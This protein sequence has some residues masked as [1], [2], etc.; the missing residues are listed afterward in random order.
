VINWASFALYADGYPFFTNYWFTKYPWE[1]PMQYFERSPISRVGYVNT[2]TM[3]VTG[4]N[5]YRTPMGET[6]QYYGALKLRGV[7]TMMIRIADA[8]HGITVRPSNLIRH[9]G[10]I[11]GW[12]EKIGER[13]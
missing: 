1:D 11:V 10:Y 9:V 13:K 12:F 2:P 8:G 6:E 3:L 7:E 5:D 4:E